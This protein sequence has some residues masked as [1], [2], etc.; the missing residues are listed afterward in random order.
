MASLLSVFDS[1]YYFGEISLEETV[2]ILGKQSNNSYLF[3]KLENG[4]ITIATLID[5]SNIL[6]EL[7]IR[8]CNCKKNLKPIQKF[9]TL[10]KFVKY[11]NSINENCGILFKN[12][13][14]RKNVF[15]LEEMAKSNITTYFGNSIDELNLPK[16]LKENLAVPTHN[17]FEMTLDEKR[18]CNQYESKY[19]VDQTELVFSFLMVDLPKFKY[20]RTIRLTPFDEKTPEV[21]S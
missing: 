10:S 3:R 5:R 13:V 15:S 18:A 4:S 21:E 17:H 1:P 2:A 20:L 12:P 16:I 8:N 19:R 7:E 11:C 9:E 6:Y 14:I